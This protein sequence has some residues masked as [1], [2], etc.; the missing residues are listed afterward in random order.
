MRILLTNTARSWSG[1]VAC[2]EMVAKG[3]ATRGCDVHV[4]T[5]VGSTLGEKLASAGIDVTDLNLG[6]N[7]VGVA[8]DVLRLRRL[9][10]D[11]DPDLLH[12]NAS[13]D[14]W[15]CANT[16]RMLRHRARR[17]RTKHNLKRIRSSRLNR[18]L[19]RRSF[20]ALVA[21]TPTV[22]EHLQDSPVTKGVPTRLINYGVVLD[23]FR[24]DPE[25]RAQA[26]QQLLASF[27]DFDNPFIAMYLSR[28]TPR[29][30]PEL[31][32]KS[33]LR[34]AASAP[35]PRPVVLAVVGS[36]GGP[37]GLRCLQLAAGSPN[38]AF[39]GFRSDVDQLLAGADV[40]LLPSLE[41]AFGLAVVEAMA[42]GAVP[43]LPRSGAF[44]LMLDGSEAGMLYD[45]EDH[46]AGICAA[47]VR[48]RG[49]PEELF[50]R[51]LAAREHA[52]QFDADRMVDQVLEFYDEL[53]GVR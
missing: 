19:Y 45:P 12:C 29:K 15:M 8:R 26:R 31:A 42:C 48:L 41:E 3:L 32:V 51:S 16:F 44:P 27:P 11:F 39:L 17:V 10:R 37:T 1:E 2:I 4:A 46:V 25:T 53:L 23:G 20:H 35:D 30:Q 9:A 43:I 36:T 34:L 24:G 7:P 22:L 52:R 5:R 14:S 38:I 40:F 28:M 18:S 13:K 49:D 50:R 33:V 21:P 6:R 47:L